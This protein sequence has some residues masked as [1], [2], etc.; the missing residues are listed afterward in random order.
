MNLN[1]ALE[2]FAQA[3]FE[4]LKGD[5]SKSINLYKEA[6]KFAEG[7]GLEEKA[8]LNIAELNFQK[9]NIE[10]SVIQYNL[11]L[12]KFPNSI[13][14]DLIYFKIGQS[15]AAENKYDEAISS[16]TKILIEFPKSIYYDDARQLIRDLREKKEKQEKS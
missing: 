12:D 13:S 14:R 16:L 10:E 2:L 5:Y 9:Q 15:Y 3:E 11:V 6:A 8:L 7:S 4:E 1:K